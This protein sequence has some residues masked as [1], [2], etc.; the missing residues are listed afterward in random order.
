M[1]P[2]V[3]KQGDRTIGLLSY[4]YGP[5]THEEHTDPHLVAS[6]DG[7]APDPGRDPAATLKELQLLLDQPVQAIE[8]ELRPAKH[9]WHCSVR[10]APG[11][12]ILSDQEWGE[13]ARRVVAATG[14]DD[15]DGA[16]CRWAAVRHADDHVHIIATLVREDGH[17]PNH[18]RSGK[19]AQAEC[20]L[21]EAEY[22]LTAVTPG[23]GT[24][25]K[26]PTSAER[27]KAER[28][29]LAQTPREELRESVR[30]AMAGAASEQEFFDRLSAAGLLVRT[31]T[32]PS[33][34]LL[35]YTVALPGDRNGQGEPVFY[36]GS[37]LAPDLSLPRIRERLAPGIKEP[38]VATDLSEGDTARPTGPASARRAATSPAWDAAL[39]LDDRGDDGAAAAQLSATGELLDALAKTSSATTRDE[40]RLAAGAFERA[41]RSHIRAQ[42]AQAR[43]LRKAAREIVYAGPSLGR[44]EDGAATAMVLSTLFFVVVA[45]ARWHAQH[46][47]AQQA[48]AARQAAEHLRIAYRTAAHAPLTELRHLGRRMPRT[49]RARYATTVHTVL[50]HLAE[51]VLAEGGWDALAATLN[52]A[53]RAGADP[54]ALLR[55]AAGQRELHSA[56]SISDVLV[57]RIRH[58]A[59]LPA[60]TPQTTTA[61]V[62][63]ATART[64]RPVSPGNHRR[65]GRPSF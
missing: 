61:P 65:A 62:P 49:I 11:D 29:S 26:R 13:I 35:G 33:G 56:D 46:Q 24:A 60:H 54:A 8:K 15:A 12:R 6:F 42:H 4:L 63:A 9:V 23:D 52:D 58:I 39:L 25:A 51:T 30:R 40:L 50:P 19:R 44:G 18:H 2:R 53:A 57:W 16:G 37:K 32:A 1:I 47:H 36:S 45:A 14:I 3:H 59:D 43:A 48:A 10:A 34:D 41:S 17:M 38:V 28:Q 27:H 55:E 31:R 22:G 64:A 7:A 21:I 20:R 5:G